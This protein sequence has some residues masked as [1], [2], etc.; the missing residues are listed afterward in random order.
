MGLLEDIKDIGDV[1][2]KAGD[3]DLYRR[4]VKLE[5]EV[6]DLTREKRLAGE[7]IAELERALKFQGELKFTEPYY[8]IEGDPTPF[9]P[10]CWDTKR[11]ASH[12]VKI[13]EPF[14]ACKAQCPSCKHVYNLGVVGQGW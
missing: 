2:K 5:G 3:I 13:R 6:I 7:R 10:A 14:R 8:W 9:C 12:I 1:I 4:I 11:V